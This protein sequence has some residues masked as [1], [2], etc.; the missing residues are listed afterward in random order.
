[1]NGEV[2][3]FYPLLFSAYGDEAWSIVNNIV[4]I[5]NI[6]GLKDWIIVHSLEDFDPEIIQSLIDL[7]RHKLGEEKTLFG[8]TYEIPGAS[9]GTYGL[10]NNIT[11]FSEKPDKET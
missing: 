8:E 5:A 2:K 11:I 10:V 1:M 6:A 9:S 4:E 7:I 3:L